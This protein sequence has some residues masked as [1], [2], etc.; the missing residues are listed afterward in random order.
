MGSYSGLD[1]NINSADTL[2]GKRT[3]FG[4][5]R[6]KINKYIDKTN[7]QTD[8]VNQIGRLNSCLLV[9]FC[10]VDRNTIIFQHPSRFT[11]GSKHG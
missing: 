9:Y 2:S 4:I 3:L 1:S 11:F 7:S 6:G 10:F 5:G 8:I